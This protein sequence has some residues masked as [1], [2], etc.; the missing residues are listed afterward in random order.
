MARIKTIKKARESKKDR[1]CSRCSHTIQPGESYYSIAKKVYPA[2]GYIIFYCSNHYPRPSDTLSGKQSDY[3]RMH[4]DFEDSINSATIS[5]DLIQA[6]Q[7]LQESISTLS[8]D[9]GESAENIEQ[10]FGHPTYQ[11]EIMESNH[12][13]LE[14]YS[15]TINDQIHSLKNDSDS[16][17]ISEEQF[18]ELRELASSVIEEQPDLES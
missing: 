6:L 5:E 18:D 17:D 10:G 14:E 16:D 11:S 7:D 2:G 9:Y 13:N 15:D 4:E 12:D 1:N 8:S 3:A